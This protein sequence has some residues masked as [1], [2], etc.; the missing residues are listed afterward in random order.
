MRSCFSV[1]A[2]CR[3]PLWPGFLLGLRVTLLPV[4]ILVIGPL[5]DASKACISSGVSFWASS[6]FIFE[7]P[8]QF[9]PAFRRSFQSMRTRLRPPGK[10]PHSQ[11]R[12]NRE[13]LSTV[14]L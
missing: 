1:Q 8:L 7:L 11:C 4:G 3:L 14:T 13:H 9:T 10:N 2:P 6:F 5:Y 12:T